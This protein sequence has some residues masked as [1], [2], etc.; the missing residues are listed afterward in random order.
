MKR[1]NLLRWILSTVCLF[2]G[3]NL[4][5][6]TIHV[7][8]A[9]TLS[10]LISEKDKYKITD[11]ILTGELNGDDIL[12][13]REM[14]G[15][16]GSPE[17]I[18]EGKLTKLNLE[19]VSFM[20]GGC[21]YYK[22]GRTSFYSENN[23]LTDFMFYDLINLTS[24]TLPSSISSIGSKALYGCKNLTS[25]SVPNS[26]VSINYRAFYRCTGLKSVTIGSN[27]TS[28]DNSAFLGCDGL[29]KF[30]VSNKNRL[31]RDV[32]GVLFTKDKSRLITYP[33]SRLGSYIIPEGTILI[34]KFA[35]A[36]CSELTTVIIPNSVTNIAQGAFS[37]CSKL[38]SVTIGSRVNGIGE[39]AF[40][41]CAE[42]KE[43]RVLENNRYYT[44]IDGVLFSKDETRIILYPNAMSRNYTIPNKVTSI[45]CEAFMGCTG[46][47]SVT[48]PES[49][50][51][52]ENNAFLCCSEIKEMHC[53]SS[54]PPATLENNLSTDFTGIDK[55]LCILY[56]PKGA[57]D[58]YRQAKEWNEFANIIEE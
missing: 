17:K 15:R 36:G 2:M 19:K 41:G 32:R 44:A 35:F 47:N 53:K 25:L 31:Y 56:V 6:A 26:V 16:G 1:L 21:P 23:K 22:S 3:I 58:K 27:V 20:K 7:Q 49:I 38:S 9:G 55:E 46:L 29:V 37:N 12:F 51:L 43:F 48:I 57:K 33:N 39:G 4:S 30:D 11:L 13:I 28:I 14:A 54:N 40:Y 50:T 18:T 10:S 24:L 52:I 42:L 8:K 5:A 45:A 34:D